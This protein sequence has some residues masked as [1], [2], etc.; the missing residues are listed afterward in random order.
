M[1]WRRRPR[2]GSSS[3]AGFVVR[4]EGQR[5]EDSLPGTLGQLLFAYLVLN[6]L[7]RIDRDELLIAVYG[8][9]ATADHHAR[10]SVL[11]SKLRR[12]VG[13]ELL[14][15]R[16]QIELVAA[17]G[18]LRRRRGR[19]RGAASGRV[20]R[21]EG[22]VGGRLGSVRPRLRRREPA[23]APRPRPPVARGLEATPRR[24]PAERAG[25]P[26]SGQP[27]NRRAGA[28]SSRE[29][30]SSAHRARSVPRDRPPDPDGGARAKRERRRGAACL[31]TGCASCSEKSSA[32]PP[33]QRC[34]TST[35]ACSAARPRLRL[36]SPRPARGCPRAKPSPRG[37]DGPRR[38]APAPSPR[39]RRR[40]CPQ[41]PCRRR[42]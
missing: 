6:R 20:A 37:R 22:R 34:R 36:R 38:C 10:L 7:R 12:V 14:T 30:C 8:E 1:G 15:G 24:R 3:A 16:A 4:L 5:V 41:G 32:S 17:G 21:R 35:G 33:A 9:D 2:R 40:P 18:R 11:L 42:R 23:P 31:T 26:G 27:R 19:A 39:A 13:A 29:L 28:A 25:V